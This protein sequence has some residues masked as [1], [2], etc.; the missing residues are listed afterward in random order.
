LA[1]KK[2][3]KHDSCGSMGKNIFFKNKKKG[4]HNSLG[5]KI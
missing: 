4:V 5:K 3:K 1:K 2:E